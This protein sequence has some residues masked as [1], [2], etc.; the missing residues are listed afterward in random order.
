MKRFVTTVLIILITCTV[1]EDNIEIKDTCP[2]C[3]RSLSKVHNGLFFGNCV[4]NRNLSW[5]FSDELRA[6]MQEIVA[7]NDKIEH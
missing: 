3:G 7:E 4:G 1:M 5:T 6:K 2:L